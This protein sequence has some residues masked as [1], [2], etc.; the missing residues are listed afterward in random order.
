MRQLTSSMIW[1]GHYYQRRLRVSDIPIGKA[2]FFDFLEVR[3]IDD[4]VLG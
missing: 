3:L 1:I 4:N 2:C